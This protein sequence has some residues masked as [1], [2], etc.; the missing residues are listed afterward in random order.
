[1]LFS[2]P[3]L[4]PGPGTGTGLKLVPALGPSFSLLYFRSWSRSTSKFLIPSY[5]APATPGTPANPASLAPSIPP[6][7]SSPGC[8]RD[9][10]LCGLQ[11]R[12]FLWQPGP[13]GGCVGR[14][15]GERGPQH[16]GDRP[17]GGPAWVRTLQGGKHSL[18]VQG[19]S[20]LL[21]TP[22]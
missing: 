5:C 20:Y 8:S 4:G 21:I 17:M 6:T 15:G 3:V 11:W 16:W 1:M 12:Q 13:R 10:P 7:T 19:R 18:L 22:P 14:E 2:C 9:V